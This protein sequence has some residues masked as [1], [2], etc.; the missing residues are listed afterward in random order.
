MTAPVVREH[1]GVS[2]VRDDLFPGGTKARFFRPMFDRHPEMVYA[3]PVQGGAQTALAHAAAAAG[4]KATIFV[5]K[6]ALPHDRALE[7]KRVGATV[8]QV[9]PGY[10]S[11]VQARAREYCQATGAFLLP[12]G[13]DLPEAGAIIAAAA[14]STGLEPDEVWCAAGSGV[15]TRALHQ[16]W[17]GARFHAV[18]IGRELEARDVAG[19]EIHVYPKPFDAEGPAAPF[20]ADRHYDAKAWT[21]CQAR[22]VA[23]SCGARRQRPAWRLPAA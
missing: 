16:A 1:A 17:P 4:A 10:L 18:Q 19:A 23:G 9:R 20:P 21:V 13:A 6:R 12:F 11:V 14:R 15:L 8:V 5:A 2:V 3:S 7:A 22:R